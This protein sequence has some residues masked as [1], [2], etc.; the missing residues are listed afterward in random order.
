M[1]Q[2]GTFRSLLLLPEFHCGSELLLRQLLEMSLATSNVAK[3][4]AFV[5]LSA[6]KQSDDSPVIRK[7]FNRS[8]NDA[9]SLMHELRQLCS[10]EEWHVVASK[11]D[12]RYPSN[13]LHAYAVLTSAVFM[14]R[15]AVTNLPVFLT[16]QEHAMKVLS[17]ISTLRIPTP[18][19]SFAFRLRCSWEKG[20]WTA[21]KLRVFLLAGRSS[22]RHPAGTTLVRTCDQINSLLPTPPGYVHVV[23]EEELVCS[24][25]ISYLPVIP[26]L[27]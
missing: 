8:I 13:I 18:E 17:D 11:Y 26:D 3:G 22:S 27:R 24:L 15:A 21:G 10:P 20:L 16:W 9:E 1:G 23:S 2:L 5:S 4:D 14:R 19:L 12:E 25:R 6:C 7:N